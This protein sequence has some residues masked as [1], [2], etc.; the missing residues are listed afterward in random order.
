[1]TFERSN[2]LAD[3]SMAALQHRRRAAA[4]RDQSLSAAIAAVCFYLCRLRAGGAA[5]WLARAAVALRGDMRDAGGCAGAHRGPA[6]RLP[7]AAPERRG[8]ALGL[9]SWALPI[10]HH[11]YADRLAVATR[12][13]DRPAGDACARQ[14]RRGDSWRTAGAERC[15]ERH[16]ADRPAAPGGPSRP[17]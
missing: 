8:L 4:V 15:H 6:L 14:R 12:L 1:R 17:C 13:R 7:R 16:A 3:R 2:D 5:A 11:R 10:Q 9:V